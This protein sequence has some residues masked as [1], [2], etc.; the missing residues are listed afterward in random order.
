MMGNGNATENGKG[1]A[2][3]GIEWLW[4]DLM[5]YVR[6]TGASQVL[7]VHCWNFTLVF[8]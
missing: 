5:A 6:T 3:H 1:T 7:V 2:P 8:I 4:L